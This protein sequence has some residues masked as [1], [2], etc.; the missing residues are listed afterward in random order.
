MPLSVILGILALI[1]VLVAWVLSGFDGGVI[2]SAGDSRFVWIG[3]AVLGW[4]VWRFLRNGGVSHIK[5]VATGLVGYENRAIAIS[6]DYLWRASLHDDKV[7]LTGE[8]R[9]IGTIPDDDQAET[10]VRQVYE[11]L[12]DYKNHE[13]YVQLADRH[14]EEICMIGYA[15][16]RWPGRPTLEPL[17]SD[18]K[19]YDGN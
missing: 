13:L 2:E 18:A 17:T 14:G 11:A 15:G 9:E 5:D 12:K 16:L 10:V 1:I 7:L 19:P 6:H 4:A 8:W 3:V